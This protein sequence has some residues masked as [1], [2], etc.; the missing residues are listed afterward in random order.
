MELYT[1]SHMYQNRVNTIV[2]ITEL[3]NNRLNNNVI[4]TKHTIL[5]ELKETLP[6]TK[7]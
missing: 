3:Q 6:A 5:L 7:E 1:Y 2:N 4:E